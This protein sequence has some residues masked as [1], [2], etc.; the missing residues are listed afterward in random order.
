MND[1]P[2]VGD[3]EFLDDDIVPAGVEMENQVDQGVERELAPADGKAEAPDGLML[4]DAP[5]GAIEVA[6]ASRGS[7]TPCRATCDCGSRFPRCR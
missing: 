6:A 4:S 3:V 1:V 7:S 2:L 5:S